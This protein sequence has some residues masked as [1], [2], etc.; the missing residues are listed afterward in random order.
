MVEF[1]QGNW[2]FLFSFFFSFPSLASKK[3]E[4]NMLMNWCSWSLWQGG[5]LHWTMKKTSKDKS[6]KFS[7]RSACTAI[8]IP[9]RKVRNLSK[10]IYIIKSIKIK[11]PSETTFDIKFPVCLLWSSI[12]LIVDWLTVI[13]KVWQQIVWVL[14]LNCK[15]KLLFIEFNWKTL[16]NLFRPVIAFNMT[17]FEVRGRGQSVCCIK[18]VE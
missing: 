14:T 4:K 10:T 5:W 15:V 16:G 17:F 7:L 2:I 13:Y 1:S 3:E 8:K 11:N 12:W 18:Q 6:E 9:R